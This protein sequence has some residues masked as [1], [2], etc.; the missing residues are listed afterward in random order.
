[1][2]SNDKKKPV[3]RP[4][5]LME[6]SERRLRVILRAMVRANPDEHHRTDELR[7]A[8]AARILLGRKPQRGA[9]GFRRDDMLEMMAFLYS[10]EAL[11]NNEVSI[12]GLAKKVIDMPGGAGSDPEGAVVKDLADKF[13][14]YAPELLAAHS[15]DGNEDFFSFYAPIVDMFDALRKTGIKIDED[16]IPVGARQ[17]R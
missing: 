6:H 3:A 7:V 9:P 5:L 13:I 10:V 16:V 14:A 2:D 17:G 1:M 11:S 12:E 15:V 8:Q 4:E